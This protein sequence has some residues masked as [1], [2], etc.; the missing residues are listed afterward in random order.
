MLQ[1]SSRPQVLGLGF[2][3]GDS[4][5]CR[6]DP[7]GA[8]LAALPPEGAGCYRSFVFQY[9]SLRIDPLRVLGLLF[10]S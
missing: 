7:Q 6:S 10:D 4:G 5:K 1:S 3:C 9:C 2:V 8:G